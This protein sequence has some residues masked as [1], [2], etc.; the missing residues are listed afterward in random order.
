MALNYDLKAEQV[1]K[2][3]GYSEPVGEEFINGIEQ[4]YNIKLP[5]CLRDFYMVAYQCPLLS[6]ADIWTD[7]I[8][9]FYEVIEE[10]IQD[11]YEDYKDNPEEGADDEYYQFTQFLSKIPK[12]QW[13]EHVTNYLEIGSDYSAGVVEYGICVKDLDK[14][15][16]PV[17]YLHEADEITDWKLFCNT[18]SG[19]FMLVLCDALLCKHYKTASYVLTEAG[20]GFNL[21]KYDEA[22]ETSKELGIDLS[23]LKE[24]VMSNGK[25]TWGYDEEK[26][27]LIV[28]ST[29]NNYKCF[30]WVCTIQP[31]NV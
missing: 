2:I 25:A 24:Q 3:L 23:T 9:F 4:K 15:D 6:T 19:Y 1:L 22:E 28:A 13:P 11:F 27:T 16:P 8:R 12:E 20:F 7:G 18:L 10:E 26:N 17:Y 31:K 29:D 14:E 21:C 30:F 5:K